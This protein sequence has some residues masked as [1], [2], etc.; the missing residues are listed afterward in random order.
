MSHHIKENSGTLFVVATPI[1]NLEDIT[2][3]ALKVLKEVDIILCE[4]TRSAR[5]L[6]RSHEI[7]G[8][9][10]SYHSYNESLKTEEF[11][12]S[13]REG[14]N[15]AL[16][17][18]SG[19][20]CIS[21]PGSLLVRNA[22]QNNLKVSPIPGPSALAASL[23]AS[24]ISTDK[25]LFLGFLSKIK[26]KKTKELL[27]IKNINVTTVIYESPKRIEKTLTN[28]ANFIPDREVFVI[29]E[30]TK[31]YEESYKGLPKDL[32]LKIPKDKFRGE[33]CL[34][35]AKGNKREEPNREEIEE[36]ALK[37]MNDLGISPSD[38]AKLLAKEHE[39]PKKT[40]YKLITDLKNRGKG[41]SEE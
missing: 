22:I 11:I 13:L 19:T 29:R 36:K 1:G 12:Q 21:D 16:I 31:M 30:M 35:I 14:K 10:T 28:L 24:G 9:L 6:L 8:K 20:P 4:D 33:F 27:F 37:M 41:S 7:K 17:S 2:I 15:I 38:T 32:L 25:V 23:S 40:V 5:N 34:V 3:R 18:E 39:I 26:G